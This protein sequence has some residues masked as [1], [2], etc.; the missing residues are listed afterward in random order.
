MNDL[1]TNLGFNNLSLSRTKICVLVI[2][3]RGSG[4]STLVKKLENYLPI[5]L[6]NYGILDGDL[7]R[8]YFDLSGN[9]SDTKKY[10]EF[11]KT[12]ILFDSINENRNIIVLDSGEKAKYYY[13]LFKTNGYKIMVVGVYVDNWEEVILRGQNREKNNG[14]PYTGTKDM[15]EHSLDIITELLSK[16]ISYGILI[17]N[18]D[19]NNPIAIKNK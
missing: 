4:K 15:W 6:E 14:K 10:I 3:V 2:G 17:N 13:D 8:T 5:K 7:I 16:D 1:K 12:T 18:T 11:I 19:Y 9:W